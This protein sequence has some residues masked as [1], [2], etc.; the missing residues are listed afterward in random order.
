VARDALRI[1]SRLDGLSVVKV[2]V[3]MRYLKRGVPA[4]L[5]LIT[6]MGC[7]TTSSSSQLLSQAQGAGICRDLAAWY[8]TAYAPEDSPTCTPQLNTDL[9]PATSYGAPLGLSLAALQQTF[10]QNHS[11]GWDLAQP[12]LTA[13]LCLSAYGLTVTVP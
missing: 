6:L 5:I 3:V 11:L 7:G 2:G 4:G 8:G 12:H 1:D 9:A 13:Q 10:E